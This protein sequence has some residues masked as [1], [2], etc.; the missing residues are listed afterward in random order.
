MKKLLLNC[1]LAALAGSFF[2]SCNSAGTSRN[3]DTTAAVQSSPAAAATTASTVMNNI[4]QQYYKLHDA[5]V[6]ADVPAAD[7]SAARLKASLESLP[8]ADL[9]QDT[10]AAGK[11][12]SSLESI[13]GELDGLQGE[14]QIKGKRQEFSM[15]SDM[16]YDLVK[17]AHPAGIKTYH[18]F[19]PMAFE[20][21]GAYWLSSNADIRNPYYGHDML[22]CGE[23][24]D[25]LSY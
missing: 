23:V 17:A 3:S 7:S 15:V 16:M 5:M 9:Q 10:A 25:T 20:G 13:R 14:Q 22:N 18:Q 11:I 2:M 19:C 4:L 1:A 21:K 6:E 8:L 12:R 24:K